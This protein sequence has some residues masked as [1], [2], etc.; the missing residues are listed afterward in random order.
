MGFLAGMRIWSPEGVPVL[1][2]RSV[3]DINNVRVIV[4]KVD[5]LGEVSNNYLGRRPHSVKPNVVAPPRWVCT[6]PPQHT[7]LVAGGGVA[8]RLHPPHNNNQAISSLGYILC[9]LPHE[10]NHR[11]GL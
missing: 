4:G 2:P 11:Q 7:P 6:T 5:K 3:W 1:G 9:I 8:G 10:P